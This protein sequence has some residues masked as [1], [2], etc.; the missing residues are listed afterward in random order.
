M[1]LILYFSCLYVEYKLIISLCIFE[2]RNKL[3]RSLVAKLHLKDSKCKDILFN[4]FF[5][6]S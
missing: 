5:L 6:T 1:S 4:S 3:G 2:V